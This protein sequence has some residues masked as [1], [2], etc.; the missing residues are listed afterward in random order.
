MT[1]GI[2]ID[3]GMTLE[4]AEY[5][6]DAARKHRREATEAELSTQPGSAARRAA[7]RRTVL[8]QYAVTCAADRLVRMLREVR[9]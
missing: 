5:A 3:A 9:T 7:H 2:D 8:W 1:T 4:L 6:Y